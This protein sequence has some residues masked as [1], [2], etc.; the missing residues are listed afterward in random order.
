MATVNS[1]TG[2]MPTPSRTTV[3]DIVGAAREILETDGIAGLTMQA[4]AERVG[5]RAPS[6]YKHVSDREDL[7]R[8]V[9]EATI[10]DLGARLRVT[11]APGILEIARAFRAFAHERPA[12]YQLIFASGPRPSAQSLVVAIEPVLRATAELAGP[13]HALDAART[14]TAWANG[15]IGMELSGAFALGGDIDAA[16]EYGLARLVDAIGRPAT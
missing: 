2:D 3:D 11:A 5:V 8:L 7:V 13:E 6:L 10:A 16:W 9:S 12:G 14:M 4:V 1:Y 15:F